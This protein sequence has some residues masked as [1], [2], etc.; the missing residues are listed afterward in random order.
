MIDLQV[1]VGERVVR[2]V[3]ETGGACLV[4]VN[5]TRVQVADVL[6]VTGA[7]VD[8]VVTLPKC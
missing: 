6:N 2:T 8:V 4:I 1:T 5:Q 3:D 7:S